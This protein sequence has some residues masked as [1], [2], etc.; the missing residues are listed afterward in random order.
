VRRK[1][2][3]LVAFVAASL[4]FDPASF[5]PQITAFALQQDGYPV[6]FDRPSP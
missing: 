2:T 6:I 5:A 3:H 1:N 4:I